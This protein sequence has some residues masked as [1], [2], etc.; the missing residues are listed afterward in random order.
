VNVRDAARALAAAE[1][2][3]VQLGHPPR[4]VPQTVLS[5]VEDAPS[6]NET[7]IADACRALDRI[8]T[9]SDLAYVSPKGVW[10]DDDGLDRWMEEQRGLRLRLTT[11]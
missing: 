9:N 3:A 11:H 1:V 2:V 10:P 6:P 4:T 7:L 5:F 8:V